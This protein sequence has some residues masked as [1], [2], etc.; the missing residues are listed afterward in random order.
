MDCPRCG[1][2]NLKN[3]QYCNFCGWAF[4][5]DWNLCPDCNKT[6]K[7]F[8]DCEDCNKTAQVDSDIDEVWSDS[9]WYKS[10]EES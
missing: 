4:M 5:S 6:L 8:A 7:G 1:S 10:K 3:E 2:E 9:L